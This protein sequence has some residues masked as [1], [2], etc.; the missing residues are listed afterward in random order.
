MAWHHAGT[1]AEPIMPA[2]S[3]DRGLLLIG[4]ACAGGGLYFALVGLSLVPGPGKLHGPNWI[5]LAV[6]VVFAAAGVNALMR[7]WLGLPDN[8]PNLPVDT[9]RALIAVQWFTAVAMTAALAS[10]GTWVAFGAGTH[11]FSM[12]LPLPYSW[13]E[14]IGRAVFGF[15]AA[16]TWLMAAVFATVGCKKIFGKKP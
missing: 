9:P 7:G 5:A 13:S 15:G 10:I 1:M 3:H 16:L 4:A 8:E 12:S 14:V 6:G 11:N 2:R